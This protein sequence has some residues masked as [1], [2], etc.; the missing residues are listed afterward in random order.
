M[1]KNGIGKK[2]MSLKTEKK[3]N[4]SKSPKSRLIS[5]IRNPLNSYANQ[6]QY[7]E[8]SIACLYLSN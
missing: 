2:N 3:M 7:H 8:E 4:S 6:K 1:F 5:Q